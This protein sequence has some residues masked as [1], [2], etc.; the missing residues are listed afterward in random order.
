M[1]NPNFGM[2][3]NEANAMCLNW[4]TFGGPFRKARSMWKTRRTNAAHKNQAS[5]EQDWLRALFSRLKWEY[6]HM[7]KKKSYQVRKAIRQAM[8]ETNHD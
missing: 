1:I 2:I 4:Y 7:G 6:E 5:L 3:G 8:K